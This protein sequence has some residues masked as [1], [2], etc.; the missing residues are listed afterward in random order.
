MKFG[1][2]SALQ[3]VEYFL[4]KEGRHSLQS[5]FVYNLYQKLNAFTSENRDQFKQIEKARGSWLKDETAITVEDLGAGSHQFSSQLRK[6]SEIAQYSCSS[7]KYSLLYHYL[8]S[9]TPAETVI[10]LGT[11]LGINSCY[12]AEATKG[13]LYTF[14]GSD[15]LVRCAKKHLDSCEKINIITGEISKTLPPIL[16]KLRTIDFAFIDA[17][18]TYEHTMDYFQQIASKT[19]SDSIVVIGDIHWSQEMNKA[20]RQIIHREHVRVSLDFF[21]C[22]VL[23]FKTG[24]VKSHYILSY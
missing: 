23:F 5:P 1:L 11:C 12:L 8:C 13:S 2:C 20:W 24:L 22:G 19:H 17:N 18:H 4:K 21:E 6:I 3:Y 7:Q 15:E 14:E 16:K 9:L 10:E